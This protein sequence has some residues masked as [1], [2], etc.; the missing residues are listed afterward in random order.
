MHSVRITIRCVRFCTFIAGANACTLWRVSLYG[1][2]VTRRSPGMRLSVFSL[3]AFN[4]CFFFVQQQ[5]IRL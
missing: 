4:S 3:T 5:I 1:Y 2:Y